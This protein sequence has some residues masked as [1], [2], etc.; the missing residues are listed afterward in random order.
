MMDSDA[1]MMD[2]DE[3][4]KLTDPRDCR[5]Q[6]PRPASWPALP[7]SVLEIPEDLGVAA[8]KVVVAGPEF[9][10]VGLL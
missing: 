3:G 9:V 1:G 6:H 7:S 5:R 4:W 10:V 8:I 2:C